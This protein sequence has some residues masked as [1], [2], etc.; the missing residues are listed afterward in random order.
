MNRRTVV[1]LSAA[2]TAAGVVVL[3]EGLVELVFRR[4]VDGLAASAGHRLSG[5][6]F[7]PTPVEIA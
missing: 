2:A 7:M 4:V 3:R 5:G 6:A 1:A